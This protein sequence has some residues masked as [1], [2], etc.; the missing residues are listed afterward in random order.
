MYEVSVPMETV[1]PTEPW[2]SEL[3]GFEVVMT[4]WVVAAIL[5][6]FVTMIIAVENERSKFLA[7]ISG[8]FLGTLG[9]ITYMIMGETVE[10]RTY[11]AEKEKLRL[12]K[13]KDGYK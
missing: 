6:G 7:F 12:S 9:I 8:F 10:L 11:K 4:I 3:L 5:C 13:I 1:T 2:Y